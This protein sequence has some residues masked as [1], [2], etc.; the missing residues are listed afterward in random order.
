MN[1]DPTPLRLL[2]LCAGIGGFS[3]AARI[4]GGYQTVAFC[5]IDPFCRSVLARHWPEV[6]CHDDVRTLSAAR[7]QADGLLPAD[8]VTAGFPCQDIS[9][10]GKRAGLH[11]TRSSLFFEIAR[12]VGQIRPRWVLLENVAALR[13][14]GLPDV[15]RALHAL[16][17][18]AQWHVVPASACGAPHAR[19]RCWIVAL[20]ADA[21]RERM[22]LWVRL[23]NH[24][25]AQLAAAPGSRHQWAGGFPGKP[26]LSQSDIR[27]VVDGLPG[28]LDGQPLDRPRLAI[29]HK[30]R[31]S[32][33]RALGNAVVPQVAALFLRAIAAVEHGNANRDLDRAR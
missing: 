18:D 32:A 4:A 21:D 24:L 20:R 6:P 27:R 15:L 7:L 5:E 14:R 2:D 11:G 22:A 28:G 8:I 17:Y 12:L 26:A 9:S 30:H 1:A 23:H 33:L 10:A 31:R 16:G 29:V 3:L 19:D 25:A 13:T